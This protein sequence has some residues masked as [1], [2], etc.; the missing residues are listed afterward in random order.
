MHRVL[1]EEAALDPT[2]IEKEVRKQMAERQVGAGCGC[3]R[4]RGRGC[5]RGVVGLVAVLVRQQMGSVCYGGNMFLGTRLGSIGRLGDCRV[6]EPCGWNVVL[7]CAT[8]RHV[9][10]IQA[11]FSMRS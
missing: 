9:K 8:R 3:G 11:G 7:R 10:H 1:G 2:A 5:G 6:R 4:G